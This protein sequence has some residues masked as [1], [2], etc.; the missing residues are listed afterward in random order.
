MNKSRDY[1]GYLEWEIYDGQC[2]YPEA[3]AFDSERSALEYFCRVM[4][5]HKIYVPYYLCSAFDMVIAHLHISVERYNIGSDF[6]PLFDKELHDGELFILVNY[7]G[8]LTT[9]EI[10]ELQGQYR[11]ILV[12]NTQA[13][14]QHPVPNVPTIYSCRKYFGVPDGSYLFMKSPDWEQYFAL[15]E[16]TALGHIRHLVGRFEQDAQ[17]FYK[18]FQSREN[19]VYRDGCKRISKFSKNL[20]KSFDYDQIAKMRYRNQRIL[21]EILGEFNQLEFDVNGNTFM[22][23][24]LLEDGDWIKQELIRH[25]IYVPTLWKEA[26]HFSELNEFAKYLVENLVLLPIDQRY[27]EKDMQYISRV[28]IKIMEDK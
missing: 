22:Y 13:F 3:L 17:T 27:N 15:P 21:H 12:D 9:L 8:Q 7:L 23:P 24:L 1:G 16:E 14:F 2:Y 18:D 4:H 6:R 25:K 11:H 19:S 28:V 26:L 10:Q 20:L 5:I